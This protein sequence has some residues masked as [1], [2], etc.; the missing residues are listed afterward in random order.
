MKNI[1][2]ICVTILILFICIYSVYLYVNKIPYSQIKLT[3]SEPE[4]ELCSQKYIELEPTVGYDLPDDF[5]ENMDKYRVIKIQYQVEN[6][7]EKLEM[8]DVRCHPVFTGK[9]QSN[10]VTYNSGTGT[11][12]IYLCPSGCSGFIQYIFYNSEDMKIEEIYDE[13]LN[14][15]IELTFYTDSLLDIFRK[16]SG[17]GLIGPGKNIYKFTIRDCLK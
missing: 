7:S 1:V 15:Q 10:I 5:T 13:I 4:I 11:Y 16:N 12:Y 2:K 6:C 8:K 17:H 14:G 3:I 9:L